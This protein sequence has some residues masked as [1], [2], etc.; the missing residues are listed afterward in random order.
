VNTARRTIF[1]VLLAAFVTLIPAGDARADLGSALFSLLKQYHPDKDGIEFA[2]YYIYNPKHG[3]VIYTRVAGQ[4]YAFIAILVAAKAARNQKILPG[5]QPFGYAQCMT[6]ITMFDAV[7]AKSGDYINKYGQEEH[8]KGYLQAQNQEAKNEAAS[9]LAEYVPYWNEIPSICH[10]TFNT[11]FQDEKHLRETLTGSWKLIRGAFEDFGNGNVP[12]GIAK[13]LQTGVN[14]DTACMIADNAISGGAIGKTPV[15]GS[16]AKNV[17]SGFAGTLIKGINTVVGGVVNAVGEFIGDAACT[18]GIGSCSGNAPLDGLFNRN[19]EVLVFNYAGQDTADPDQWTTS[20][21]N[22]IMANVCQNKTGASAG[23]CAQQFNQTV[24]SAKAVAANLRNEPPLAYES[25]YKPAIGRLV[26]T[27]IPSIEVAILDITCADDLLSKYPWPGPQQYGAKEHN[28]VFRH[29]CRRAR[30]ESFGG[31]PSFDDQ[32]KQRTAVFNTSINALNC[33]VVK[34]KRV[35]RSY[36][37]RLKCAAIY[38]A[39]DVP[40]GVAFED[41]CGVDPVAATLNVGITLAPKAPNCHT[42]TIPGMPQ[43]F[44]TNCETYA[45]H[46]ACVK[47]LRTLPGA[48]ADLA[49]GCRLDREKARKEALDTMLA[50]MGQ[51]RTGGLTGPGAC[52]LQGSSFVCAADADFKQCK[53]LLAMQ[54]G[55]PVGEIRCLRSINIPGGKSITQPGGQTIPTGG[56]KTIP[57]TGTVTV[58]PPTPGGAKPDDAKQAAAGRDLERRGCR[59]GSRPGFFSCP[60]K[61]AFDVCSSYRTKQLVRGCVLLI[62]PR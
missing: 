14:G 57:A 56:T 61:A 40:F 20:W 39:Y 28:D 35:C 54:I 34:G 38:S 16:I 27:P 11:D 1:V 22:T 12:A 33:T 30:T 6:P 52:K 4:D 44:Q 43:V 29:I 3:D 50:S 19:F 45:D 58:A 55:M 42:M 13:L 10:F 36:P 21:W 62:Q 37:D 59:P 2:R 18:I 7:F 9:Q 31:A 49:A 51:G 24:A 5:G 8:V 17:C 25:I 48:P 26:L 32:L 46:K 53:S 41:R 15:V 60:T 23:Q 47:T